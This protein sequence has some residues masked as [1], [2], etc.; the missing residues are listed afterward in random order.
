MMKDTKRALR[1]HHVKRIKKDRRNYWGGHARQSVKVLGKCSRTPC[2]CSCYLCGHKRKH[3]GAKFSEK[4][5][6]LQYM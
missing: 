1:R 6:K 5:R 2:V 3:F 4:R